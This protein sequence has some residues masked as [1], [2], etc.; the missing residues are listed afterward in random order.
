MDEGTLD[1]QREAK[2]L[3]EA[4]DLGFTKAPT[5]FPERR[6]GLILIRVGGAPMALRMD[7]VA[8]LARQRKVVGVAGSVSPGLRGLAGIRGQLLVV[9]SL[10]AIVDGASSSSAYEPEDWLAMC[11]RDR[12]VALSFGQFEGY[13]EV[14]ATDLHELGARE[15]P[16]RHAGA[17]LRDVQG[18]RTVVS[19]LSVIEKLR[20]IVP[21]VTGT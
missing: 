9:Y 14:R 2:A 10:G 12:S 18:S 13:R 16:I 7:E 4:F 1:P 15:A 5:V 21:A 20:G 3:R 6:I 19:V 17:L 11:A 8:G